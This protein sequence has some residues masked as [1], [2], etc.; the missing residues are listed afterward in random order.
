MTDVAPTV[1][2]VLELPAPAQATGKAIGEIVDDLAGCE[3]VAILAPD[4][5]GLFAWNLWHSEMPFLDSLH[6]KHSLVLRAVMPTITPVNFATMV[7][8]ADKSVHGVGAFTDDFGC[9]T[10]FDVLRA[11]GRRSA[12]IGLP[13]YSGSE[14][15][16]RCAD[17]WGR[18]EHKSDE[19]LADV[20]RRMAAEERP[21]FLIAQLGT[22]DDVFHQFGPSSP[23]VLPKLR[24]TDAAL[25]RLTAH[26]T[27]LGYGIMFLS[28]HG[29][30]DV[31]TGE[32][33]GGSHGTE[34]D[35]DSLVPCTWT[36]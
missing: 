26:L 34:A 3:R 1:A 12:G 29:Q 10:L 7:A 19:E 16:G 5:L 4:A 14:L 35:E 2:A 18:S 15:L 27:G 23:K 32:S 8:G 25:K 31:G 9:E 6:A 28:D 36:R 21:D 17:V 24:E 33:K 30:H 13:G 22:T 20:I 11:R